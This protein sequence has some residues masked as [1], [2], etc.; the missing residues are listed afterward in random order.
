MLI[1]LLLKKYN[2]NDLFYNS[3]RNT[4]GDMKNMYFYSAL[5]PPTTNERD[6]FIHSVLDNIHSYSDF[7]FMLVTKMTLD[8]I[9]ENSKYSERRMHGNKTSWV[10]KRRAKCICLR[11]SHYDVAAGW[12]QLS[13]FYFV[14]NQY[15]KAERICWKV[16]MCIS[17]EVFY[18]DYWGIQ[19]L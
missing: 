18:L 1:K 19:N 15:A 17:P 5:A 8:I 13:N 4:L 12:L 7:Q 14:T 3:F 6:K 9:Y 2:Q 11:R 10:T 16:I